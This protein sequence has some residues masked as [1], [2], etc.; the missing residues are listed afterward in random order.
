MAGQQCH[1]S[2]PK[3]HRSKKKSKLQECCVVLLKCKFNYI[4]R[5][6]PLPS[7][8]STDQRRSGSGTTAW[9]KKHPPAEQLQMQGHITLSETRSRLHQRRFSRPN[10]HF[11]AFFEIYKKLTFSQA[12]FAKFCRILQNFAKIFTNF[13]KFRKFLK[14]LQILT[15]LCKNLAE[16]CKI[17]LREGDF[18]VDFEKRWK[19]RIWTRKSASIQPLTSFRKFEDLK[20]TLKDIDQINYRGS[21]STKS[22]QF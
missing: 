16:I 3:I 9:T 12:N 17:C 18:L 22:L 7:S 6:C 20:R 15:K 13:T 14:I 21:E 8:S 10:M 5:P 4:Q 1:R 2:S 11:F 19:M